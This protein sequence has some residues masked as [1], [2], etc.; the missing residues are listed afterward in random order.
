LKLV[1]SSLIVILTLIL[2]SV[3]VA[4]DESKK[5]PVDYVNPYMGNISHLL[6]PTYPTIHLPNSLMRVYP[7]RGDYTTDFLSG[8]PLCITRHRRGSGFNV[9]PFQGNESDIKS[10]IRFSYD[11]E[12][13]TPYSYEVYLDEQQTKVDFAVSHQS[14]LYQFNYEKD[15][16]AYIILNSAYG[17]LEWDGKAVSGYQ[18]IGEGTKLW[19]Y[20]EPEIQPE[21]VSILDD[22]HMENDTS[23]DGENASLVLKFSGDTK[24]V[25]ARY[26]VS[27]IDAEQAAKNLQREIK[28]FDIASLH[29]KG[30]EIWNEALNKIE[31]DGGSENDNV[32][33]YT[34][35]Y[36]TYERP[37][38]I[39]EDGRYFSPYDEQVHSDNGVP[40][41]TDD[42]IWDSYRAHHPLNVLIDSEKEEA[43]LNSFITM[44]EEM[45]NAWMPTF[46][47]IGGDGRAMNSNH[48]VASVIDAHFKGLSGFDLEQ[49]FKACKGAITEKTLSP[50][51]GKPAG[52]ID[53]FYHEHGYIPALRRGEEE[54]H[55]EVH[56]FERRQPV[57]VTL[58]SVYDE[59]ALSLLAKEIG[60][61]KEYE[62]YNQRAYNYRILFNHETGFFHPKTD[63]GK[64]VQPFDYRFS[65]GQGTRGY[66]DENNGWTYRWDVQHNVADLINLMGGR[67][68][69]INNLNDMFAEPLG[70]SKYEFYAQIPDQTGN[71]GQF[72]IGNEPSLHIPYLYNY[73]GQPW[74]TQKRIR[75]LVEQWFRNDVMGVPGDED[76]GG[77]SAFVV[78]SAIG[79]YHLHPR[80]NNQLEVR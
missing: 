10:I 22:G 20:F 71:V 13:V 46:P 54:T 19:V 55:P 43:I 12:K 48:G 31:V 44:T 80:S 6:V 63:D 28:D 7:N 35:L 26:G 17:E 53:A 15:G 37:I 78:F 61:E 72:S 65:G 76:G 50:F 41:Y 79:F 29:A 45:E 75:S 16:P 27:I 5:E 47:S 4:E 21:A 38:K 23:T 39:S 56:H 9:S 34:S 32:V 62:Y 64:F 74:K 77:M 67:E 51:S 40:F 33:F 1:K 42:W 73:A 58:G 69:F 14:A 18:Q 52:E 60:K 11:H 3:C 2:T 68:N 30:R 70:K 66:Y 8:L 59:W 25:R 57:A 24:V 49:A 36:R